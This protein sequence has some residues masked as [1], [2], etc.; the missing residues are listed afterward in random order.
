MQRRHT[1]YAS[2]RQP[3]CGWP[4]R[5]PFVVQ[6]LT[7]LTAVYR[8]V[9]SVWV[10][11]VGGNRISKVAKKQGG[12]ACVTVPHGRQVQPRKLK[13]IYILEL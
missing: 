10:A 12:S 11:S 1:Q 9:I 5:W 3:F 8:S 7:P 6:A 13:V 2:F 4:F